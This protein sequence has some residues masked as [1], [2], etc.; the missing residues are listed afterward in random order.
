M[1]PASD[2]IASAD[3]LAHNIGRSLNS[4]NA[5]LDAPGTNRVDLHRMKRELDTQ[6]V[7]ALM[8]EKELKKKALLEEPLS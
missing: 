5:L 8:L 4:I 2:Y 3:Q 6:L 1:K 7:Y